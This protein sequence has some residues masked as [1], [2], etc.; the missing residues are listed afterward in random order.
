MP[1]DCGAL[2]QRDRETKTFPSAAPSAQHSQ[3]NS[4]IIIPRSQLFFAGKKR[5]SEVHMIPCVACS[6]FDR[7]T[8][9][10]DVLV[11]L[12]SAPP[13]S[14]CRQ[15]KLDELLDARP[16]KFLTILTRLARYFINRRGLNNELESEE[17]VAEVVAALMKTQMRLTPAFADF[18]RYVIAIINNEVTRAY[19]NEYGYYRCG[20][21]AFFLPQNGTLLNRCGSPELQPPTG[22]EYIEVGYGSKPLRD[23][24][25]D[26]S[27]CFKSKERVS[28]ENL[29]LLAELE[30]FEIERV[31]G[32]VE[33]RLRKID[34][35]G[36]RQQKQ[37]K[38]IRLMLEGC[39]KTDVAEQIE[40]NRSN[41]AKQIWGENKTEDCG[42]SGVVA[43]RQAGAVQVFWAIHSEK[44]FEL[45]QE[46]EYLWRVVRLRD[47]NA[48]PT[49]P[50]F[51][52]IS[53]RLNL[54]HRETV[55]CYIAGWTLIAV[56]ERRDGDD[57]S[58]KPKDRDDGNGGR[59]DPDEE[60]L[61][62][63]KTEADEMRHPD[64]HALLCYAEDALDKQ[65]RQH[66]AAH[67]LF[68]EGCA[69][70][71]AEIELEILPEMRRSVSLQ[72]RLTALAAKLV[73]R[74][75]SINEQANAIVFLQPTFARGAEEADE[76]E[77]I[78]ILPDVNSG[79]S[80]E[81]K[82][83]T[84]QSFSYSYRYLT[85]LDEDETG[86]L[87]L[88]MSWHDKE[89]AVIYCREMTKA[90]TVLQFKFDLKAGHRYQVY[91]TDR[92]VPLLEGLQLDFD[93]NDETRAAD[94]RSLLTAFLEALER[95]EVN[96][97]AAEREIKP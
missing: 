90:K 42:A 17:I 89:K 7:E 86:E 87:Y 12:L 77:F 94:R 2:G 85:I 59:N 75:K 9:V 22:R 78:V 51:R 92:A 18:R 24:L 15:K 67:V 27:G 38:L 55:E 31:I 25:R 36:K 32:D 1:D 3:T 62:D 60:Q 97:L 23:R 20:N 54:N 26:G 83:L 66:I 10:C 28:V 95:G 16:C 91:L 61:L 43:Y 5:S 57:M 30:P 21:C 37:I 58:G 19:D 71:L 34:A 84:V 49:Q 40:E 13:K 73:G 63:Q 96:H 53:N 76:P 52:T 93:I 88:F 82:Q 14:D 45:K 72:E 69:A 64:F 35:W 74:F 44:I 11:G 41:V 50:L 81:W 48:Q 39:S 80:S 29:E 4:V 33:D 46:K 8:S 70:E 56:P 6:A 79:A 65:A 68:C 47:F